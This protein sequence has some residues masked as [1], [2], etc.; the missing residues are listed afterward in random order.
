VNGNQVATV[1][2]IP[3]ESEVTTEETKEGN[4]VN[5]K[6]VMSALTPYSTT[7]E[8][9]EYLDGNSAKN[10]EIPDLSDY[11]EKTGLPSK[12]LIY[13]DDV[14]FASTEQYN[15]TKCHAVVFGNSAKIFIEFVARPPL[16]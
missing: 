12:I 14:L 13:H 9:M 10:S 16:M 3:V 6:A 4:A 11:A 2:G 8:T 7:S 5:S 1:R 15:I